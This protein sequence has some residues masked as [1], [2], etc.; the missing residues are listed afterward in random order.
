M[1]RTQRTLFLIALFMSS[2]LFA[3]PVLAHDLW[4]TMDNYQIDQNKTIKGTVF[5]S[6][7]FPAPAADAIS[8]ERMERFLFV[9]PE[10]RQAV[11][12]DSGK[13]VYGSQTPFKKT[14]TY[15]AVALP[16]NGFSTKTPDG[17]QRGKSRQEVKD[18]IACSYSQK[19]A[20]AVFSVGKPGGDAY[21]KPL[22]HAMEIIP[23]KD[24]SLLKTGDVLPVKVLLEGKPARTIVFGTYARFT[25]A[26]NTFAYATRT[27]KDG[28]AEV[29]MIHDG[30]WLLIVK[31]E[32]SY[33][34]AAKCDQ[35]R[36]AASLTFEVK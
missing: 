35:Q 34:D 24:P 18:P 26:A 20:K 14:G 25:E 23:M 27:D 10:G 3:T 16:V 8:P 13:G 36:W 12:A 19:F 11:A 7:H 33:P 21:S 29:K 28:V 5:S 2:I 30:V 1:N 17:Y 22:G 6:H 31:A 15:V 4:I 9:S 32:D